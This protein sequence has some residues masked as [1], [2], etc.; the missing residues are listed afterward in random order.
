MAKIARSSLRPATTLL[1]V[2]LALL[3]A[4]AACGASAPAATRGR[5]NSSAPA[6]SFAPAASAAPAFPTGGTGRSA[7]PAASA[8]PQAAATTA[9]SGSAASGLTPPQYIPIANRNRQLIKSGTVNMVVQDV[10]V[11]FE[12]AL[13]I[14]QDH[15]GD[16]LQYTNTKTGDKRVADLILQVESGKFEQAMNALR[17]MSGIVERK[18]DKADVTEVTDEVID[19]QAQIKNLELTEQQLQALLQKTTRTDE[20]L[21][22]QREINN[23][24]VELDR[25]KTRSEQLADQTDLSTITLHL[26][27]GPVAAAVAPP[28]ELAWDPGTTAGRAW[29]ASLGIL[30][31]IGTV[32][33]TVAVFCW[34][35][36]PLL[37][38]AW[39]VFRRYRRPGPARA[40]AAPPAPPTPPAT[41]AGA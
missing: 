41:A 27:S 35:L 16:V 1:L 38:V 2:S 37:L 13:K 18:V 36:V 15:G 25:L 32:A 26:E 10:D 33:I 22:I 34:W 40:V 4:L 39:L 5:T 31:G 14:A 7:P 29:N 9:P 11:S 28:A 21:S 24:R 3:A 8:A 20:I 30:Q 19:V 6:A 17:R 23:V 12:A